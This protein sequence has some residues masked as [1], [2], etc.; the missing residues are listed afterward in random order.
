MKDRKAVSE[1]LSLNY[2][3]VNKQIYKNY[4]TNE[5]NSANKYLYLLILK[6]RFPTKESDL[7]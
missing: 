2:A 3:F 5:K 7:L 4:L 6:K 1:G